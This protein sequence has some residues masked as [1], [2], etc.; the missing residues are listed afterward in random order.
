MLAEPGHV[1]VT[2]GPGSGKTTIALLKA[3]KVISTLMPAQ[4]ILFL[5]F[6]RAAVRQVLTRCKAILSQDERRAIEVQTYHSFCLEGLRSHGRLL[7]G[8][9]ARIAFPDAERIER[10]EFDGDWPQ[11]LVRRAKVEGIFAFDQFAGAMA[12]IIEGCAAVRALLGRKYPLIIVD[13]FQDTDDDQ[14]RIIAALSSVTTIF[15]LADPEQSIFQYDPKVDPLRLKK[16][17]TLLNSKLFDLAGDNHR[18]PHGG[19]LAFADAVMKNTTLPSPCAEVTQHGYP[20]RGFEATVHAAVIW[21]FSQ[22]AKAKIASPTIALLTRSNQLVSDISTILGQEHTYKNKTLKP[23]SHEVIWDAELSA[24]AAVVLASILEWP[25]QNVRDAQAQTLRLVSAYYRLKAATDGTQTAKDLARQFAEAAIVVQSGGKL[26]TKK[27]ME[28]VAAVEAG[29]QLVGDPVADW[30]AA[31]RILGQTTALSEIQRQVRLVRLFRA[32][33]A[34][35]QGLAESWVAT[36]GYSGATVLVKKVLDQ[37]RLISAEQ[38]PQGVLVMNIHKSKGKEFDG[39]ILVEGAFK[40]LFFDR[41]EKPPFVQSRRLL[42]VAIT[43]ARTRVAI[44]RPKNSAP[45]CGP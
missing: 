16:A 43:R 22:L 33:D 45:L 44:V 21:M 8:H 37:E 31:S 4:E 34:L 11:E 10:A 41:G 17:Q 15:C 5:S 35:G 1:L 32:T 25:R 2:G 20:P 30:R 29:V 28:I 36:G 39:V 12:D 6:S 13:E 38:D 40:S 27:A 14:W 18:S 19:I 23:I 24:A 9:Q 26:K 42:R 3:K 7:N